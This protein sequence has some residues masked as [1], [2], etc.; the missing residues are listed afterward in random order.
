MVLKESRGREAQHLDLWQDSPEIAITRTSSGERCYRT[1]FIQRVPKGI[2]PYQRKTPG[3]GTRRKS[4]DR[5][6]KIASR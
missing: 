6:R 5:D 2:V 4:T 3:T 1:D